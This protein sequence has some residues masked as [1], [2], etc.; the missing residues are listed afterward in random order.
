MHAHF[1]CWLVLYNSQGSI[2]DFVAILE[3]FRRT[4]SLRKPTRYQILAGASERIRAF[5][6][7]RQPQL[8]NVKV[9]PQ[10]SATLMDY[11]SILRDHGCH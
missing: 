8:P 10:S 6:V 11:I 5:G 9:I 7:W 3:T 2:S 1:M 4:A